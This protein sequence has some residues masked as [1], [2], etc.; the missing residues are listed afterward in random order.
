MKRM[1]VCL[2]ALFLLLGV[3]V[4]PLKVRGDY[5]NNI[6]IESDGSIA[7]SG[8]PMSTVDNIT[9]VLTENMHGC[10]SIDRDNVVLDG[11]LHTIEPWTTLGYIEGIVGSG[12]N[13]VTIM[14]CNVSD[15]HADHQWGM[16]FLSCSN[17]TFKGNNLTDNLSGIFLLFCSHNVIADNYVSG[18]T[19]GFSLLNATGNM[20][21]GNHIE[22]NTIGIALGNSTENKVYHNNFFNNTLTV[23]TEKSYPN[24]LDNGAEGNYWSDYVGT[25]NNQDGIGDTPYI[26]DGNNTDHYP[27]VGTFRDFTVHPLSPT[28]T[29]QSIIVISNS[30]V[31]DFA[32]YYAP[33]NESAPSDQ[34]VELWLEFSVTGQNGTTGFCRLQ[35]PKAVMNSSLYMVL[36]DYKQVHATQLPNSDNVTEYLYFTYSHST[37][38]VW[39]F[40]PEFPSILI[41]PLFFI[42]TLFAVI[43]YRKRLTRLGLCA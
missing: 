10:I 14:N 8:A 33:T 11:S 38:Q 19:Q 12:I 21:T 28:H 13:N 16:Q 27:L 18:N 42:I 41:L 20:I 39:V 40:V 3:L 17:M 1:M 35:I 30:T 34:L 7:P 4:V 2:V 25:D 36:V 15:F 6:T 26:I 32:D 31:T 24:F 5:N 29:P 37:H 9:Y 23:T 22:N 43:V